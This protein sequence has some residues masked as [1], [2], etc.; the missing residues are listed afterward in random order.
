MSPDLGAPRR[1]WLP[2]LATALLLSACGGGGQDTAPFATATEAPSAQALA[3]SAATAASVT[4][5]TKLSEK[6]IGRTLFE[7]EF[8]I[9]V[10][11]GALA[12]TGLKAQ[13]TA[14]GAGTTIVQGGVT[15]GDI[16]ASASLT[17]AGTITLRQ[18]RQQAF[19]LSQLAWTFTASGAVPS[20]LRL[21]LNQG[22]IG[23]G[24]RLAIQPTVTDA[25]GTVIDPTPALTL[26]VIAPAG[27]S[28]GAL[29]TVSGNQI[30][31]SADT[32]GGFSVQAT[33]GSLVARADFVV[34]ANNGQSANSGQFADLSA[35]HAS[36]VNNLGLLRDAVARN[37]NSAVAMLKA[38]ITDAG[39]R[40]DPNILYFG[41]PFAPDA[42]FVPEASK[43]SAA[44]LTGTPADAVY[45][46]AVAQLQAKLA[47][48]TALLR[49]T[50]GSDADNTALLTQY[51]AD[52]TGI[53]AALKS[54]GAQP[55]AHGLVANAAL[56]NRLLTQDM[57]VTMRAIADRAVTQAA[58]SVV[59]VAN[60][61]LNTAAA[62]AVKALSTT[63]AADG[64]ASRQALTAWHQA[65]GGS[66]SPQFLLSGLL[67]ALGPIGKLIDGMY[68]QG[69]SQ[70][71]NMMTL[72]VTKDLLDKFLTQTLIIEGVHSA[73]S[74]GGPY[75]YNYPNSTIELRNTSAAEM[76]GADAYLIGASAVNA[77]TAAGKSLKPPS[78]PKSFKEI[79]D[80]FKGIVDAIKGVGE[81]YELA[82]QLPTEIVNN[83]FTE[84]FG[85]LVSFSDSCTEM[86]YPAGFKNVAGGER[87]SF[88]VLILVRSGGPKPK[89]GSI[90]VNFVPTT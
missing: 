23:A 25:G 67:N 85:C 18:D 22:V 58:T 68:G 89:Y 60:P 70:I 49:A 1:S 51:L 26:Q 12:Q 50:T 3:V 71:Q 53:A 59:A 83:S 64:S 73:S 2:G 43:L 56:L 37:D 86:K 10:Q 8:R 24:G 65:S 55:S 5:L 35:N 80:Y 66:A 34:V 88:T 41:S 40:I 44:G 78:E 15:V 13:L 72:L 42:G 79:F 30:L 57:P 31:T 17:P 16:A 52:L 63:R 33:L 82:H 19:Q 32:R 47:Q 7:Y 36:L 9:T 45:A 48:I 77:L 29:P 38:A 21:A 90:V 62:L 39:N 75:A 28:L 87:F 76:A 6:R 27:G 81:A 74:V 54:P 20:G 61:N 11:N 4:S 84:N 14:A 69:L 46:G